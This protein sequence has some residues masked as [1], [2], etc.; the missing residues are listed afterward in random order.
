MSYLIANYF[1]MPRAR[2]FTSLLAKQ[3]VLKYI[4]DQQDKAE[5]AVTF[6]ARLD[7]EW[8]AYQAWS[9]LNPSARRPSCDPRIQVK[10]TQLIYKV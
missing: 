4:E 7:I 2:G 3:R 1:Q 6:G 8:E 10:V 5:K 9:A